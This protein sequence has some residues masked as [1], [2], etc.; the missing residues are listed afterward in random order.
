[1]DDDDA[2]VARRLIEPK[3]RC[4][5]RAEK[6][7]TGFEVGAVNWSHAKSHSRPGVEPLYYAA[8]QQLRWNHVMT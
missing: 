3:H 4:R 6:E 1:M 8:W 7:V 2:V 5:D